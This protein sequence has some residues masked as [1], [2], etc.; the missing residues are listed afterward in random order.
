MKENISSILFLYFHPLQKDA[1]TILDHVNAFK[2]YSKY[3]VIQVNIYLG[4]PKI[5]NKYS[6]SVIVLHYS[7]FGSQP[8]KLTKEAKEYVKNSKNSAIV[9]FFQDE[10][11]YCPERI[12]LINILGIR[13][14]YTLVEPAF[15][16]IVYR[17][18]SN[19]SQIITYIPGYVSENMEN[20]GKTFF[21]PN[22]SR[23]IDIGY[24]GRELSTFMGKGAF[25]KVDIAHRFL[26]FNKSFSLNCDIETSEDERIYGD[27]WY[28]FLANC[29][30][31]IG[32]EAG[33]T[34]FDLDG[35]IYRS[36]KELESK[37]ITVTYEDL[38]TAVDLTQ[39]EDKIFYRT[40][41]PRH[42][43]AAALKVCQILYE[44]HYSGILQPMIHY[45][46]LKKDFSNF[47]EVMEIFQN[48]EKRQNIEEQAYTDL[49]ISE[50]FTYQKF[51]QEFDQ[52]LQQSEYMSGSDGCD[53]SRIRAIVKRDQMWQ[54][55][56][57]RLLNFLRSIMIK[58]YRRVSMHPRMKKIL[59]KLISKIPY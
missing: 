23:T 31:V 37:N 17:R 10:H 54:Y 43:E 42:F 11:Q 19:V 32:V 14:I 51:I 12:A 9:A 8:F 35:N 36:Y 21:K 40:I 58:T 7:L 55:I 48:H 46:P 49:I 44:G 30:G 45:I 15:H 13:C 20:I 29:R 50:K 2:R 1:I 6:F 34:I 59:V 39:Y 33:A 53:P 27:D 24:R 3:P 5:L 47:S 38:G 16:D 52:M 18:L 41:S 4:F 25:E 26:E 28:R 22:S 56:L 57:A